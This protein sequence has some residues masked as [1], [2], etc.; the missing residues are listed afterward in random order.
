MSSGTRIVDARARVLR[1]PVADGIAMSFAPLQ[2][3]SMVLVELHTADGGVGYGESWVNYPAWAPTERLAT[4]REGVFPLLRGADAQDVAGMQR[5]QKTAL[6][7]IGRQ[8][9]APGPILQAISAVDLALWDLRGRATGTAA[10]RL[11]GSRVR[12]RIPIYASSLG[13]HDVAAD[14]QRCH[15][16]GHTAVKLKVGFGRRTD[17]A[18]L[19]AARDVLG[20]DVL[21][22]AD[23][24]QAW[25]LDEAK[26]MAPVL[27]A[28]EV[29][30]LEEPLVGDQLA[31]LEELHRSTGL[32]IAT[33]ENLYE[34]Q[35][36][37]PYIDS[38]A[39]AAIQPDVAKTGGLTEAWAISEYAAA[40]DKP[41]MPHLYGGA[42]AFAATLQLAACAPAVAA[43][44]YD[45]RTNPLRDPLLVNPPQPDAGSIVLPDYPG[46]GLDLDLDAVATYTDTAWQPATDSTYDREVTL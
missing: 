9:G 26:A 35:A 37:R 28:Y 1:A 44:E 34:L 25:T 19:A 15:Q 13:P 5:R 12:E 29:S 42:L 10:C 45:V 4:L 16:D 8:W 33:G 24:N 27:A 18:N 40:H 23:A 7:P 41:V 3:R 32:G 21:L 43:V 22:Y 2:H 20:P 36:F 30:L 14:A 38:P 17:E 11:V 46:L 39:I 6:Q 31:D